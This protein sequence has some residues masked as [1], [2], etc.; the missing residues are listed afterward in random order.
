[1]A[2][3]DTFNYDLVRGRRVVYRGITNDPAAREVEHWQAGKDFDKLV[4]RGRAKTRSGARK[5][6]RE[7]LQRY[8]RGHSGSNPEYNKKRDG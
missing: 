5:A 6:E 2:Q 8:R 7:A 4:I 1:M 3:R